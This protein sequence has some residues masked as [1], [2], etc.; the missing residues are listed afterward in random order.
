MS[1]GYIWPIK[2]EFSFYS[3]PNFI[4]S[5]I[6]L[7]DSFIIL[8]NKFSLSL[9]VNFKQKYWNVNYVPLGGNRLETND[10]KVEHSKC[11]FEK[12]PKQL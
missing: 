3:S 9:E 2:V 4:I 8:N 6:A 11:E 5:N 1:I 7:M 12:I 10:T